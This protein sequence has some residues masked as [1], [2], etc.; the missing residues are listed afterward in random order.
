[1]FGVLMS[2]VIVP[3]M[4]HVIVPVMSQVIVPLTAR[5]RA[6]AH[7]RGCPFQRGRGGDQCS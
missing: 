4:S 1:M 5:T 3:V 6:R 7:Q 2:R